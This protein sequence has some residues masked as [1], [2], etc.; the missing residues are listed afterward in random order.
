MNDAILFI[1][2][3]VATVFAIGPLA[4]AAFLDWRARRN[5]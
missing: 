2:G 5:Q 1:W 4:A 3:A